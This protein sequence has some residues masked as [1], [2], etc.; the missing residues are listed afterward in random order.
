MYLLIQLLQLLQESSMLLPAFLPEKKKKKV[1]ACSG[2]MT[3]KGGCKH[4]AL[5]NFLR[6][7]EREAAHSLIQDI[8]IALHTFLGLS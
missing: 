7:L 6:V 2:Q 1:I 4:L 3:E 5:L 8:C